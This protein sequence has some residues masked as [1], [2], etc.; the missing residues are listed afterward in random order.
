MSLCHYCTRL[1]ARQIALNPL[2]R[3][4]QKGKGQV[5]PLK[6]LTKHHH[7]LQELKDCAFAQRG[8]KLCEMFILQWAKKRSYYARTCT[9]EDEVSKVQR[10]ITQQKEE[11]VA[12][13]EGKKG[14]LYVGASH[15]ILNSND[16]V[17]G[18][19]LWQSR[20]GRDE[21]ESF[22]DI[23]GTVVFFFKR[24]AL[25]NH[26][27]S[28]SEPVKARSIARNPESPACLGLA[29][30]WLR[31]CLYSHDVCRNAIGVDPKLPRR[32][33][34]VSDHNADLRLL[35]TMGASGNYAALS[36]CW[37]RS[38]TLKLTLGNLDSLEVCI[39]FSRLP[40][41]IQDAVVVARGMG[42]KY[43]WV[44]ALCIIQDSTEDWIEQAARMN[45]I[46]YN[47]AFTIFATQASSA[48]E[49][50][51]KQ[52]K[53]VAECTL[54]WKSEHLAGDILVRMQDE[55]DHRWD[56]NF[57]SKPAWAR[58][59]WTLQEGLSAGRGLLFTEF[60]MSWRCLKC[61]SPEN[62]AYED[63][64]VNQC[65]KM[66]EEDLLNSLIFTEALDRWIGLTRTSHPQQYE[67]SAEAYYALLM[68]NFYRITNQFEERSFTYLSDK[69]PATA[70][71]AKTLEAKV[72]GKDRYWAG[73]WQN[74]LA[75]GLL[76][77]VQ[78]HNNDD[79]DRSDT[80]SKVVHVPS[81]SWASVVASYYDY[82]PSL[83]YKGESYDATSLVS[84]VT[85][86]P[87]KGEQERFVPTFAPRATIQGSPCSLIGSFLEKF[88]PRATSTG[89]KS[90]TNLEHG[91]RW[92]R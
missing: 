1:D 81:W 34:D 2:P 50:F 43:L 26:D 71:L 35:T 19:T 6:L 15:C 53:A 22:H 44:D 31:D 87:V 13:K 68:Y 5:L 69:L 82:I 85:F 37:G 45:D 36:Y 27:V 61:I 14:K 28:F 52:R 24:D 59:G 88:T 33:I 86:P 17:P 18:I 75:E 29:A 40:K 54:P 11:G 58:R 16:S 20:E 73:L 25:G 10:F 12:A 41:T 42:I 64:V 74:S 47:A 72:E 48:A 66:H 92:R 51:L 3:E 57:L 84:D 9:E 55:Y 49:G 56:D 46:Y 60:Q 62:G 80:G 23:V 30:Q 65:R 83:L 21:V 89:S 76:W 90:A 4:F 70:G 32:V 63:Q 79:N 7:T 91:R 8:C 77:D 78:S 39:P 67:L 38:A